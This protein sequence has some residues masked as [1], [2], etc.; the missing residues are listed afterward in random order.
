MKKVLLAVSV[1]ALFA[2]GCASTDLGAYKTGTEVTQAQL[3]GFQVGKSTQADVVQAIGQPARKQALGDKEV[4][5]YDFTKIRHIGANVSE[6][7]V[8]EFDKSGKL[9][10]SYKTGN[11]GKTGNALLDAAGNK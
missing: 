7:T 8:F 6:S 11:S 5:Y 2:T 10:Q 3:S 1:A 4:W 9:L